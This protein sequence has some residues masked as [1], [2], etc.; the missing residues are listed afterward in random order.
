MAG[1]VICVIPARLGS[2]RFPG[3][4]LEPLLGFPLVLHVERRCRL[5]PSFEA[6]V[7]AT[8]DEEIR[9]AALQGGAQAV[10]TSMRHERATDRVEEAATKLDLGLDADDLVV[11]VQ[12]DEVLVTPQ[13][14]E[15]VVADHR[16]SRAMVVNLI[17]RLRRPEDQDDPNA[18]KVTA[19]P[20]GNALFFSRSPI[21]SRARKSDVAVY[22]QTGV[23]SFQLGFLRKFAELPQTPLEIAE[24]VDMLRLIE[25]RLP[26]RVVHT[27]VETIGVDTPQDLARAE[28]KL[29]VDAVT[30]RYMDVT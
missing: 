5:Y 9:S 17:S 15:L 24:S 22:Q 16:A 3:K 30:R 7:V 8:C 14:L 28:E 29:R 6:V 2:S 10:M 18:V 27:E 13:M 4:P 11:M 25:H 20:Q 21:P 23:I 12:G 1:R 26:L 19:D